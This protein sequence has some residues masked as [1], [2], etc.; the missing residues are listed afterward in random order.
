MF[1]FARETS[2]ATANIETHLNVIFLLYCSST[3]EALLVLVR[4]YPL[5]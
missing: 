4:W 5:K 2:K 1:N 3:I